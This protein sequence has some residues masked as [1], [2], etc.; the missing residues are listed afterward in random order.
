MWRSFRKMIHRI[1]GKGERDDDRYVGEVRAGL[2]AADCALFVIAANEGVD[3]PTKALWRECAEVG[4]PLN[5]TFGA[6][7][8]IG[9]NVWLT[10]SVPANS[11]VSQ[12]QMRSGSGWSPPTCVT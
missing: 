6:G 12:A 10:H 11:N 4:M 3:E 5:T 8:T 1:A 9:G 2:R 7:S